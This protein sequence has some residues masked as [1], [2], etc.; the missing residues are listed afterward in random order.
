MATGASAFPQSLDN[1]ATFG[2]VV[3]STALV[4]SHHNNVVDAIEALE[5]FVGDLPSGWGND[6]GGNP[7]TVTARITTLAAG[8]GGGG[9]G[10]GL[11]AGSF[12]C[13]AVSGNL[14]GSHVDALMEF[15]A[16]SPAGGNTAPDDQ[17]IVIANAG[18]YLLGFYCALTQAPA[19]D[20][21]C[22][23]WLNGADTD[24][25]ITLKP[26]SGVAFNM[27]WSGVRALAVGDSIGVSYYLPLNP[28]TNLTALS[29]SGVRLI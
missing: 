3:G 22:G 25:G 27:S 7:L 13:G 9:G 12:I 24:L 20:Y 6:G 29:F 8:G 14:N 21:S 1:D 28:G 16:A 19:G 4:P 23:L 5:Q 11:P 2:R 26:T 10:G 15:A 18:I 17:H